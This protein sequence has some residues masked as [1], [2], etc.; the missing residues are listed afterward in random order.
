MDESKDVKG[1]AG[2]KKE[3]DALLSRRSGRK[4]TLNPK[5]AAYQLETKEKSYSVLLK[6]L[7]KTGVE[8]LESDVTDIRADEVLLKTVKKK[9]SQWLHDYVTF[10][11]TAI[12]LQ[13]LL[14]VDRKDE[15]LSRHAE[16][17]EELNRMKKDVDTLQKELTST[18][19][20]KSEG[21]RTS[22]TSS[23]AMRANLMMLRLQD[24]RKKAEVKAQMMAVKKRQQL[25]K[26]RQDLELK[27]KELE[28][29]V[30]LDIQSAQEEVNEK[31]EQELLN[32][33][34]PDDHQKDTQ[35]KPRVKAQGKNSDGTAEAEG[36]LTGLA[37]IISRA[38]NQL[39]VLEPEVF[40]GD[41]EQFAM[42]LKSFECYI[43]SRT[44][45]STERL[46]Y[47]ATYTG[48]SAKR[49]IQGLL[50]LRS[51]DAYSKAKQK[52]IERYGNNFV[53]ANAYR[54]R[55]HSWPQV[56]P[57]D[58]KA[59]RELSD[60]LEGCLVATQTVPGLNNLGN[61]DDITLL[62]KRLPR[63][64]VDRWRRIVDKHIYERDKSEYPDMELFV[65]FL[66]KEARVAC[67]PVSLE[68][69]QDKARKTK[70][71]A[72]AFAYSTGAVAERKTDRNFK[73]AD[74]NY[75]TTNSGLAAPDNYRWKCVLCMERHTLDSRNAFAKMP[76]AEP[77]ACCDSQARSVSWLP[78]HRPHLEGVQEK[79]RMRKVSW[80]SPYT[81]T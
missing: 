30:Q 38:Q 76:L 74:S 47:L 80:C 3:D 54:Q 58:G 51:E 8:L 46:H 21:S 67:G 34:M 61:T 50:R 64:L 22:L 68:T 52:L 23:S 6:D 44:T 40:K 59:L 36:I 81:S 1:Q 11:Q 69:D 20:E 62:L 33:E 12:D 19:H 53:T 26:E 55:L 32:E 28:L 37:H 9:V 14:P 31:F 57:G 18:E 77:L 75:Q 41:V 48:G 78:A 79:K 17:T 43:E 27:E 42:W 29:Q 7:R 39:P 72:G 10:M 66:T 63:Y 45:E 65:T 56:R 49:A 4:V 2:E 25:L 73:R 60:F 13:A 35:V 71:R 15:H 24:E 16:M 70:D 5:G